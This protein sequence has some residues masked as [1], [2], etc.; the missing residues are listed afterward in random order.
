MEGKLRL[1]AGRFSMETGSLLDSITEAFVTESREVLRDDLVGIYLHGS[2]VMGCFNEKKSDIN[3]L[4]VVDD[5]LPDDVKR[6]YL[7]MVVRL[8]GMAP[9]KGIEMSIVR[10]DV[11]RPFVYPTPFEL[12]FSVSHLKWYQEDSAD[13][14]ARMKGVD[15]DLAAHFTILC[16]RGKCLYGKGIQNVFG[17]VDRRHY[18]DSILFD[19]EDA[20]RDIMENPVYVVLNLCRVLAYIREGLILSKKEGGEWGLEAL[21]ERY[22]GLISQALDEYRDGE[23]RA[24]NK[25]EAREYATYMSGQIHGSAGYLSSP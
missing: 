19:I 6:R 4:V 15:R 18:L 12:H 1:A 14:I 7:D 11:C 10:E 16:H 9:E 8:N 21:P 2:A 24:W 22:H 3:L 17:K 23:G 13:Y 5:G 25:A 20:E